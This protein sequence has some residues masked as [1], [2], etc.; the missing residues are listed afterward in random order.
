M[1]YFK[2]ENQIKFINCSKKKQTKE[3]PQT[4]KDEPKCEEWKSLMYARSCSEIINITC[5]ICTQTGF[6]STGPL[7]LA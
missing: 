1:G 3:T 7:T 5:N 6:V 2:W 4:K